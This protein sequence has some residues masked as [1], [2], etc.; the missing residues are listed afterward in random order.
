MLEGKKLVR[1]VFV[2]ISYEEYRSLPEVCTQ[3]CTYL[4]NGNMLFVG[5][6]AYRRVISKRLGIGVSRERR[7]VM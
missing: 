1:S 7:C 3:D 2:G 4:G 5:P 6:E